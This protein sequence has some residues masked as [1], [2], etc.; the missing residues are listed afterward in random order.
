[1]S[2]SKRKKLFIKEIIDEVAGNVFSD[3]DDNIPLE[4]DDDNVL[5]VDSETAE[6]QGLLIVTN[7][8][9]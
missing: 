9:N 7:T 6:L 5:N 8:Y 1:L 4:N 3:C 2:T